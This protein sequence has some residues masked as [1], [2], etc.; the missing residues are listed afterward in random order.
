[1]KIFFIIF[2]LKAI[3]IAESAPPPPPPQKKKTEQ[4]KTTT[5]KKKN[6]VGQVSG[7]LGIFLSQINLH[8]SYLVG[9]GL[10]LPTPGSAVGRAADCAHDKLLGRD[11]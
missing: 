10:E 2:F 5:K 9:P 4:K 3:K 6:R 8:E 11:L 7:N 1:M